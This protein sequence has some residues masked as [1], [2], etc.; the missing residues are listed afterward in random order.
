MTSKVKRGAGRAIA[1]FSRRRILGGLG[2]LGVGPW[3]PACGS[4]DDA[5]PSGG[6]GALE[7]GADDDEA[8]A[9]E[10]AGN[11]GSPSGDGDVA[12]SAGG[13]GGAGA[14]SVEDDE[15]T[16]TLT[17]AQAEGPFFVDTGLVRSDLREGKPGVPLELGLRVVSADGCTPIEGAV[18]EVW[19]ADADG[20]YSGFDVAQGNTANA[21]GET[22]LRGF[23]AT[24]ADGRASFVT[25]YPGW[26]PG[27]TPHI[28]VMV[29]V[30]GRRLL[31]TQLYFPEAVTDAVYALEP[32]AARGPRDTTNAS[33]GLVRGANLVGR[34]T[35]SGEGYAMSFRLVVP[36]A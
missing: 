30:D 16:C 4:G 17:P 8:G 11:P 23:Q 13:G 34:V 28:H 26:Y 36:A 31:T 6:T 14:S 10:G 18:L 25:S 21:G 3:L 32:Y 33:D 9:D 29:L 12:P 19:H 15:A 20:V 27:R 1:W 7:G 2:A 22:F 5:S 35:E 24:G